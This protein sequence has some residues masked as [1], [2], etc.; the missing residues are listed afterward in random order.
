MAPT[1]GPHFTPQV[2]RTLS[3]GDQPP[4]AEPDDIFYQID[5]ELKF[6]EE[7]LASF[8]R[9]DPDKKDRPFPHRQIEALSQLKQFS[10]IFRDVYK[11][12]LSRL[13][14]SISLRSRNAELGVPMTSPVD[15]PSTHYARFRCVY[16][17]SANTSPQCETWTFKPYVIDTYLLGLSNI[18]GAS[19]D[20]QLEGTELEVQLA[21][22]YKQ[23]FCSEH[24]EKLKNEQA[25]TFA[26]TSRRVVE[27]WREDV[28]LWWTVGRL[29]TTPI[30]STPSHE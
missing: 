22:G 16:A 5:Q 13:P 20:T 27:K 18:L 2:H 10:P 30:K 26:A 21:A 11:E 28:Q 25:R 24:A 19:A 7:E 4:R 3:E 23:M 1:P 29:K 6:V 15:I 17:D 14:V 12:L 9:R 8:A